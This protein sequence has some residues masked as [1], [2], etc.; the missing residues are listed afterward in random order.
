MGFL[1]G[2][3][4]HLQIHIFIIFRV[5]KLIPNCQFLVSSILDL[6]SL[7]EACV[8]NWAPDGRGGEESSL[9][10]IP[11]LNDFYCKSAHR[12]FVHVTVYETR[13]NSSYTYLLFSLV[14]VRIYIEFLIN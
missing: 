12:Q 9:Y 13:S 8:L 10:S 5:H 11:L 4:K 2:S 14:I 3:M 7:L 6:A 1:K